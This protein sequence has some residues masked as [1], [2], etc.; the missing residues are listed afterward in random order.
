MRLIGL[1]TLS[2]VL[3]VTCTD[4]IFT[5]E[6]EDAIKVLGTSKSVQF[7]CNANVTNSKY[8][9]VKQLE[10]LPEKSDKYSI[11]GGSLVVYD[12]VRS[13]EG[14]YQCIVQLEDGSMIASN[15]AKLQ[16]AFLEPFDA[17]DRAFSTVEGKSFKIDCEGQ[18]IGMP[19]NLISYSWKVD[20]GQQLDMTFIYPKSKNDRRYLSGKTGTLYFANTEVSDSAD[21][22]C[23]KDLR[24]DNSKS[25]KSGVLE[26]KVVAADSSLDQFAPNSMLRPSLDHAPKYGKSVLLECF[27][28]GLPTPTNVWSR[29]DG[30]EISPN[31]VKLGNGGLL[32][33]NLNENDEGIYV[34]TSS[35]PLG[36][37]TDELEIKLESKP[38]W[39]TEAY[40][41]K[42]DI[43]TT[44]IVKCEASG[45]PASETFWIRDGKRLVSDGYKVSFIPSTSTKSG[46]KDLYIHDF[47]DSDVGIYQCVS[48]NS[49]GS[50]ISSSKLSIH[51]MKPKFVEV[52]QDLVQTAVGDRVT[53]RCKTE[54]APPASVRWYKDKVELIIFESS[55][56]DVEEGTL[57]FNF[58]ETSDQGLWSCSASNMF[59][60]ANATFKIEVYEKTIIEEKSETEDVYM[61]GDWLFLWCNASF[62]PY[63]DITWKWFFNGERIR[64]FFDN[65]FDIVGERL[66][67]LARGDKSGEYKCEASTMVSSDSATFTINVQ[68]VPNEPENVEAIGQSG[69]TM[70]IKWE[71]LGNSNLPVTSQVVYGR[72]V[73]NEENPGRWFKATTTPTVLTDENGALVENLFPYTFYQ[74][75]VR[76]SNIMGQGRFS[77][78]SEP[79]RTLEG[80]PLE[81]PKLL[82]GGGGE[83]GELV[84]EWEPLESS[85]FGADSITYAVKVW[86]F[87]SS[88]TEDD[89]RSNFIANP[90]QTQ[91]IFET[92]VD[93]IYEPYYAQI[94]AQN[95]KGF[96]TEWSAPSFVYS[97][98]ILPEK[99]VSN[100][101]LWKSRAF[102]LH[103]KWDPVE[104]I[105]GYTK[106]YKVSVVN[107]LDD[108]DQELPE[109]W[110]NYTTLDEKPMI[111]ATNLSHH[112][113]YV[114]KIAPFNS[115]GVGPYTSWIG[116]VKTRKRPPSG[117]PINIDIKVDEQTVHVTWRKVYK[118]VVEENIR[119]YYIKYWKRGESF[120]DAKVQPSTT[121][122]IT[123]TLPEKTSYNLAVCAFSTGGEGPYSSVEQFSTDVGT[124]SGQTGG[125]GVSI[126]ADEITCFIS[127]L[128][129]SLLYIFAH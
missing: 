57:N 25:Y 110:Q 104:N 118:K 66:E 10:Y 77:E 53:L 61:A 124:A 122:D 74:F 14:D 6:P 78:A 20:N 41:M 129:S 90:K 13:D 119:G 79:K 112:M 46:R 113:P 68:D 2:L 91:T 92:S 82:R 26:F 1:I 49:I 64:P 97:G 67:I 38:Y 109:T 27:S 89:A 50:I 5:V 28:S 81:I 100:P 42:V 96:K 111:I 126:K 125:S 101:K 72:I 123:F 29:K 58:V 35:N 114:Y 127:L 87:N 83:P 17:R 52:M 120:E 63:L 106:G 51:K 9:W 12:L 21:Y 34:C 55:R 48:K 24:N 22:I 8:K 30:K 37:I 40:S 18:G 117:K 71:T 116:P 4:R 45:N 7:N 16:F 19:N 94:Q 99:N 70:L 33:R 39:I 31:S 73:N 115:A 86:K 59:G 15:A 11:F 95:S 108:S 105:N 128:F 93:E 80:K 54:A 88:E 103:F 47:S 85:K 65:D 107:Y 62:D 44:A 3:K 69:S 56:Y 84:V 102:S 98:E 76:A 32:I 43:T 60:S 23:S 121:N 75:R 36:T